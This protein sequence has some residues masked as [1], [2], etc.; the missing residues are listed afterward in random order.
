MVRPT[1]PGPHTLF[2]PHSRQVLAGDEPTSFTPGA[3]PAATPLLSVPS[4]TLRVCSRSITLWRR[5]IRLGA[6]RLSIRCR[7][8][9]G[10]SNAGARCWSRNCRSFCFVS[11][12]LRRRTVT[13]FNPIHTTAP[14][15]CSLPVAA[16]SPRC[17]TG[18]ALG[19]S[20]SSR[21][22][23][24]VLPYSRTDYSALLSSGQSGIWALGTP[25]TRNFAHAE[26]GQPVPAARC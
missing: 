7:C 13:Q 21:E 22:G 15:A 10:A 6:T 24:F 2:G 12:I 14:L 20:R 19:L 4:G 3:P 26:G 23:G 16:V 17:G 5:P 25:V 8:S 11:A 9:A 18:K 1:H